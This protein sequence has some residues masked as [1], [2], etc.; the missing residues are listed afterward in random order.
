MGT[1]NRVV[2]IGAYVERFVGVTHA[3]RNMVL[4]VQIAPSENIEIDERGNCYSGPINFGISK[5]T[6]PSY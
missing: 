6:V 2:G 5:G 3:K 1:E 4:G